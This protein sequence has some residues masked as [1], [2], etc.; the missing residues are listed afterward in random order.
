MTWGQ[1]I[2]AA[3]VGGGLVLLGMVIGAWIAGRRP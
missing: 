2:L 3:L 1:Q